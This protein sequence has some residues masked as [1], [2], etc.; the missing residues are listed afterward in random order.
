MAKPDDL[1]T[2]ALFTDRDRADEAWG[3]LSD[4][5]IPASVITEPGESSSKPRVTW[6]E[7]REVISGQT[8]PI[9][10]K[11]NPTMM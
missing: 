10:S 1:V 4:A 3:R 5:D 11:M 6:A 2:A 7:A 8:S 9:S